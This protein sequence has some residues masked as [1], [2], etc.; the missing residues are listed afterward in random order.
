LFGSLVYRIIEHIP[1][2]DAYYMSLVS[3]STV[4]F[5]EVIPLSFEGRLFTSFLIIFNIG[6]FAYAISTITSILTDADIHAFIQD[7]KMMERIKKL[8]GHTIVC[9]FGRHATEVC[10]ELAKEKLLFVVIESDEKKLEILRNETGYLFLRG[11]AT[12]DDVL[13]EAGIAKAAS[14]VVTLPIDANNVFVVMSA[15]QLNPGI[16]I[17]SRLNYAFDETKLRR[18]G[19]DHVVMPERIGGFYMATLINKPD[20][21]EFFNLISNMG[22]SRVVFEEIPVDQLKQEFQMRSIAE[23]GLLDVTQ[24]PVIAL[25]HADGRYELNPG[26]HTVLLPDMHIVLLGDME[27]IQHYRNLAMDGID[28]P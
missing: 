7:F 19:A 16:K 10:K 2:F 18:A 27:Q 12:N 14:I 4:G 26:I 3:L 5:G 20:L 24:L 25:R 11:D 23:G 13:L 22:T 6:F 28:T 1:W 21:V 9:G 8:Q 15:R 17:I